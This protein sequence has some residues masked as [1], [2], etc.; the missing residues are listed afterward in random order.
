MRSAF[1]LQSNAACAPKVL[2]N[3]QIKQVTQCEYPGAASSS[4][5]PV[6][7]PQR[8][9]AV[10]NRVTKAMAACMESPFPLQIHCM[11]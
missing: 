4:E 1:S 2:T 10:H 7:V 6:F 8:D 5:N 3:A 11:L 9:A